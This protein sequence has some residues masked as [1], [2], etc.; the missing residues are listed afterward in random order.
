[1][2]IAILDDYQDVVRTLPSFSKVSGQDVQI[3]HDHPRDLDVLA[4]RLRDRDALVLTR[5]RTA[6]TDELL[7]RL[8]NLRIVS[9]FGAVPNI[10]VEACTRRGIMVCSQTSTGQPSYSTAELTWGLIIA[11]LRRIPQEMAAL[12]AGVWQSP[13]SAGITLRGRMLGVYGYGRIGSVVAQYGRAFGMKVLVWG[14]EAALQR[15]RAD[16]FK[17]AESEIRFFE[18][19]D[20]LSLHLALNEATRGIVTRALLDRMKPGSLIV[21][22]SRAELIEPGALL[23]ALLAGRPALGAVDVFEDEPILGAAHPLLALPNV[24]A[25]PHLG[26]VAVERLDTMF[27]TAFEQVLRFDQG[28]PI[29]VVNP[30]PRASGDT[31]IGSSSRAG[32]SGP[33]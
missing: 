23:A 31:T 22:T 13:G 10:D 1:M 28:T 33:G 30:P 32:L 25:T 29:N 5:E 9:Q 18:Q 14:R 6:I 12:R 4:E 11:A 15:A 17:A 2:K 20:V 26:Y 16:G 7:Q 19:P 27:D 24:V 3:W 21:N 8:P